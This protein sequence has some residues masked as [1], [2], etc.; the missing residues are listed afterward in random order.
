MSL[1]S[2]DFN[3]IRDLVC[4]HSAL[5]LDEG[6]RYLVDSR[7]Q[8]IV[9]EKE[10]SS[11][12]DIVTEL[13]K[14]N[15]RLREN[16]IEAMTTNETS[17]FRDIHPFNSLKK[18]VLP[19][20]IESRKSLRSL[21]IWCAACSSGQEPYSIAMML[22]EN[23]PQLNSWN[24]EILCSDISNEMINRCKEGKFTQ[25]EVN[26]GLPVSLMIKYFKQKE[27]YWYID[28]SLKKMLKFRNINLAKP[29][30]LIGQMDIVFIRNVL[31][32]FSTETKKNILSQ[33]K[34]ILK[35]DGFLVLGSTETTLN[36]DSSFK[37]ITYGKSSFYVNSD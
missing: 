28:D 19:G 27:N 8:P 29:F 15:I 17:F 37:R 34:K 14:G 21:K 20:L 2:S 7:L 26:R 13:K 10:F 11:I 1:S 25:I 30:P 12:S 9:K 16:V 23:F 3:Y 5:V 6:K 24:I 36:L 4:E 22:K 18:E 31:I 35:K 33:I 32:Y